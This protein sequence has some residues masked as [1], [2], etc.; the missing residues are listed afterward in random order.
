M[1]RTRKGPAL[2]K[3]AFDEEAILRFAMSDTAETAPM[4]TAAPAPKSGKGKERP[5][6]EEQVSLTLTVRR[7]LYQALAADAQRKGRGVEEHVVKY[8]GK[9]FSKK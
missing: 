3:P 9:H 7:E 8:L 6:G 4:E 5:T 1:K 2:V